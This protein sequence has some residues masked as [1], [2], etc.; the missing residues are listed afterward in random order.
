[1]YMFTNVVTDIL[2]NGDYLTPTDV[3]PSQMLHT[4]SYLLRAFKQALEEDIT[5]HIIFINK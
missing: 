5:K 3:L 2:Y 1:M 4:H